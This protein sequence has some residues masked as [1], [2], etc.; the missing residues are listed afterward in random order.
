MQTFFYFSSRSILLS[1]YSF[2][3]LLFPPRPHFQ[4]KK[5]KKIILAPKIPPHQTN[6]PP[7]VIWEGEKE[8]DRGSGALPIHARGRERCFEKRKNKYVTIFPRPPLPAHLR[9][10]LERR[11]RKC[12]FAF[13]C[14]SKCERLHV[15][16]AAVIMRQV[17]TRNTHT[18]QK[19]TRTNT[20]LLHM[21]FLAYLCILAENYIFLDFSGKKQTFCQFFFLCFGEA[22]IPGPKY[23]QTSPVENFCPK[24]LKKI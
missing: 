11:F 23:E 20:T 12:C 1:P 4:K 19:H 8:G 17:H 15:E 14:M 13:I 24:V 2:P 3:S 10:L 22:S 16:R 6:F 21:A 7:P 18:T 5:N 9:S